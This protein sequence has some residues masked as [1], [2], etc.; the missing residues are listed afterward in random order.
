MPV[1][2]SDS[3]RS[4]DGQLL[5]VNQAGAMF[6]TSGDAPTLEPFGKPLGKPIASVVEAADGS[7]V[8]AGFTGVTRLAS[9]TATASE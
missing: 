8:L 2:F 5:L 3:I 9:P 4:A 1:S 6:R 7:L